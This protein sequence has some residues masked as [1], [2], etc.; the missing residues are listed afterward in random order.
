MCPEV[1]YV[2]VYFTLKN[3]CPITNI[4]N[5]TFCLIIDSKEM[6]RVK[7]SKLFSL[8]YD[9]ARL[10]C[11]VS[12]PLDLLC[13]HPTRFAV[14]SICI[15][16][17]LLCVH[18]TRFGYHFRRF[19]P[20]DSDQFPRGSL[21]EFRCKLTAFGLLPPQWVIASTDPVSSLHVANPSCSATPTVRAL[22]TLTINQE[23]RGCN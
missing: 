4:T 19:Q 2:I 10:R 14:H 5:S 18:P 20:A 22:F 1:V 12:I 9:R 21:Q 7:K 16:L 23:T 17:D 11:C 6:P 8:K 13:V 15:P 3:D